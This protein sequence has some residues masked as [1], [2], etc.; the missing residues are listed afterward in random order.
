[1]NEFKNPRNGSFSNYKNDSSVS[2][3]LSI[4]QF[5]LIDTDLDEILKKLKNY[6]HQR[7]DFWKAIMKDSVNMSGLLN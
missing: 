5:M 1:M 3:E 4:D 2:K 7:C 6:S